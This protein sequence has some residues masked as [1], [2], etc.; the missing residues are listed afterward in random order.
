MNKRKAKR[1]H[2]ARFWWPANHWLSANK[3]V[4]NNL[5]LWGSLV[6]VPFDQRRRP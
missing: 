6:P 1:R 5:F 2:Y 3:V 4:F